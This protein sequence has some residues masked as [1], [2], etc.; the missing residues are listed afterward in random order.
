MRIDKL[1]ELAGKSG[2]YTDLMRMGAAS[3]VYSPGCK[4]VTLNELERFAALVRAEALEEA[5]RKLDSLF[6]YSASAVVRSTPDG[7]KGDNHG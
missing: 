6:Y 7:G 2:M 3:L 5:A 1:E 4:G